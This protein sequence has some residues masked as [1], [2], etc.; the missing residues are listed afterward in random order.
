MS[1][2]NIN[3]ALNQQQIN[4]LPKLE[5]LKEFKFVLYGGTAVALHYGHRKS[6][7]FDFFLIFH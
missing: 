5:F 1:I 3:L 7:D 4:L 2:D 6:D